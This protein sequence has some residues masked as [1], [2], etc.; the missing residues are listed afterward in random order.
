MYELQ[1]TRR[2]S[3]DSIFEVMA[4]TPNH[5]DDEVWNYSYSKQKFISHI[6]IFY[7][8]TTNFLVSSL[9]KKNLVSQVMA[10]LLLNMYLH[11]VW[12]LY[13]IDKENPNEA[14]MH[15][16]LSKRNS[17]FE[18]LDFLLNFLPEIEGKTRQ[19]LASRVIDQLGFLSLQ[20]KLLYLS[21]FFQRFVSY[22]LK[23]GVY[24]KSQSTLP[25]RWMP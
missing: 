6:C 2:V 14:S 23:C 5:L 19:M 11:V 24:S 1:L 18:R 25:L 16:L 15:S 7:S 10:F 9:S 21:L 13:T 12:S 3:N 22:L 20:L 4:R 8:T 17:L